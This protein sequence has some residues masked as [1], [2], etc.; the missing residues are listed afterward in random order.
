MEKCGRKQLQTEGPAGAKGR[1]VMGP[2]P[3]SKRQSSGRKAP[4]RREGKVARPSWGQGINH[5]P[6]EFNLGSGRVRQG[7][8]FSFIKMS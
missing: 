7:F 8:F 2:G 1:M 5:R 4:K 3:V 6:K